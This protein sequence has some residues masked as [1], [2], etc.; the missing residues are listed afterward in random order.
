[1]TFDSSLPHVFHNT[2]NEPTE[3]LVAISPPMI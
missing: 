3:I 2:T 1:M